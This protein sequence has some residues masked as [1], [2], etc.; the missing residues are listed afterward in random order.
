MKIAA[1]L[2][3]YLIWGSTFLASRY[4]VGTIP[5]FFVS[6]TRFFLA[7]LVLFA[8]AQIRNPTR[9][10]WRNWTAAISMGAL[11]F[12]VCHGGLTWA[13]RHIPSGVAAL[14]MSS[15]SLWTGLLEIVL[16]TSTR[17]NWR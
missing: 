3:I 12:L 13:A 16:R 7:G 4:A 5:P 15:T 6:G 8:F 11:F 2:A 17:P 9:L 10:T 14:L 1:F